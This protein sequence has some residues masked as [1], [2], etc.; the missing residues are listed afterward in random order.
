MNMPE[1]SKIR[2]VGRVTRDAFYV[3]RDGTVAV[4]LDEGTEGIVVTEGFKSWVRVEHPTH[5]PVLISLA[6]KECALI[7]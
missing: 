7:E 6:E 5:G 4:E 1:G 2:T 3:G